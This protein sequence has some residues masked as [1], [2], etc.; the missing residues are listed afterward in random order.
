MEKLRADLGQLIELEDYSVLRAALKNE[1]ELGVGVVKVVCKDQ[2][3]VED[4]DGPLLV[5]LEDF[6][7]YRLE[8]TG[9]WAY[10]LR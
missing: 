3:V 2:E 7:N 9:G 10:P 8:H 1:L 6:T 5:V 4:D